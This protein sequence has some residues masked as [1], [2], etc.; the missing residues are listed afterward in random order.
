MSTVNL[1]TAAA[2]LR[3]SI[4]P[5]AES[6]PDRRDIRAVLDALD[7]A[8]AA[9]MTESGHVERLNSAN[10]ELI[11]RLDA[12][13]KICNDALLPA[14]EWGEVDMLHPVDVLAALDDDR[15]DDQ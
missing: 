4:G 15:K 6:E 8:R 13:R 7:A 10:E 1:N 14:A 2:R 11:A 3:W 5:A 12:V 9:L